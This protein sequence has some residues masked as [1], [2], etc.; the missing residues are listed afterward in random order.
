MKSPLALVCNQ[1][2]MP[3]QGKVFVIYMEKYSRLVHAHGAI[4]HVYL[5]SRKFT[6][7]KMTLIIIK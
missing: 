5:M 1:T 4:G 3:M 6:M 7:M 2:V